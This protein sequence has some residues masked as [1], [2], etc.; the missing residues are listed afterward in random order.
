VA[1][2][3]IEKFKVAKETAETKKKREAKERH[4]KHQIEHSIDM[5]KLTF[6]FQEQVDYF[7]KYKQQNKFIEDE[8]NIEEEEKEEA[9][10]SEGEAGDSQAEGPIE[11]KMEAIIR[12]INYESED[13][14]QEEIEVSNEKKREK[15]VF[16]DE[17]AQEMSQETY[18]Q[19]SHCRATN[20]LHKGKRAF[21][22]WLGTPGVLRKDLELISFVLKE[23]I[24]EV[25]E[26]CLRVGGK[27]KKRKT[28]IKKKEI[29]EQAEKV[30]RRVE[31]QVEEYKLT[32]K[33]FKLFVHEHC[34]EEEG[35]EEKAREGARK[36]WHELSKEG[37]EEFMKRVE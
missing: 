1:N 22:D 35:D 27:L 14:D 12:S 15:V 36:K 30:E 13:S 24:R 5:S 4:K 20:F 10:E 11:P 18:V 34:G 25:V 7:L 6:A 3:R 29:E 32:L 33:A 9:Q 28:P 16:N 26:G 2:C 37:K 19:F 17:R 23:A 21:L 8:L 31:E